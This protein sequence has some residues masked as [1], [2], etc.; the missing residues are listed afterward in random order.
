MISIIIPVYNEENY[1]ETTIKWIREKADPAHIHEIIVSDGGS[2][3]QTIAIAAKAGASVVISPHKG[4]SAQMN[5][6]A[7]KAAASVFYFL[8]ADTLP[9]EGFTYDILN[10]VEKGNRAGCFRLKFDNSHWFLQANC[11]F[12][13]FDFN[14]FRFGDQS[15]FVTREIFLKSGGF[16]RKHIVMEDQEMIKRLKTI[17]QFTV[18]PKPVLTSARKYLQNGIYKTQGTF[19]LIFFMYQI[20]FSQRALVD[21]YRKLILQD[22]V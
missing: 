15:L 5:Y 18:I 14:Y 4:R 10:A 8:H 12:T 19:F 16:S 7:S 11:W 17:S 20:G 9:P 13:R 2:V 1:I 21:T 6:G 3:D 22:K